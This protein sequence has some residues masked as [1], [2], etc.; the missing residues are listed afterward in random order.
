MTSKQSFGYQSRILTSPRVLRLVEQARIFAHSL[1]ENQLWKDLNEYY[2]YSHLVLKGGGTLGIAHLGAIYGLELAGIRFV[3]LAGT[4]AG[5]IIALLL[6][7]ARKD[8]DTILS[9]R[10]IGIL[11]QMPTASFVDG[12]VQVRRIVNHLVGATRLSSPELLMEALPSIGRLRRRYGLNPGTE[13]MFWLQ[14]ALEADFQVGDIETL[15]SGLAQAVLTCPKELRGTARENWDNYW[16]DPVAH[17]PSHRLLNVIATAL[18]YGL[19]I[20]FPKDLH[21]FVNSY[22]SESPAIIA[23]TSMSIPLFFEPFDLTLEDFQWQAWLR[24]RQ[25]RWQSTEAFETLRQI[26]S[27]SFVDGG[28][29]S[30]FPI[31]SFVDHTQKNSSVCNLPTLGISLTTTSTGPEPF[32]KRGMALIADHSLEMIGALRQQRDREAFDTARALG[33]ARDAE[34]SIQIV[35]VDTGDHSWLNFSLDNGESEDLFARGLEG[36]VSW[37]ERKGSL[38]KLF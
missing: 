23:R 29:L 35:P 33:I 17:V 15:E 7:C 12:P 36:A 24:A 34:T 21:I 5:A 1:R 30:N 22:A 10:V 6:C 26:K 20:Q 14:H 38:D 4:S 16:S 9:D 2:P 18:P 25:Y 3:G 19:K 28:L 11:E 13:F 8:W 37:L 31:D 32:K 27:L